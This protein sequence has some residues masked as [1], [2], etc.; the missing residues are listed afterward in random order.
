MSRVD[1]NPRSGSP[2]PSSPSTTGSAGASPAPAPPP[3]AGAGLTGRPSDGLDLL[4]TVLPGLDEVFDAVNEGLSSLGR[5]PS[6]PSVPA[7]TVVPPPSATG[8]PTTSQIAR[9]RDA[10]TVSTATEAGKTHAPWDMNKYAPRNTG[11]KTSAFRGLVEAEKQLD[12]AVAGEKQAR[13]AL[14][15][16]EQQHAAAPSPRTAKNLEAAQN[17]LAAATANVTKEEREMGQAEQRMRA[18]MKRQSPDKG[19]EI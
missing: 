12:R 8:S 6:P 17:K 4:R 19:T 3:K 14:H 18:E 10:I 5:G 2:V 13:E 15:N 1:Q 7:S 11:E 16:A 9:N